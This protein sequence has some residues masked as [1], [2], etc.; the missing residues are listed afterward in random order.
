M[1]HFDEEISGSDFSDDDDAGE[2]PCDFVKFAQEQLGLNVD[3]TELEIDCP[4]DPILSGVL[5]IMRPWE[6]HHVCV[7]FSYVVWGSLQSHVANPLEATP[8]F[9]YAI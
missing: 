6:Y 3:L 5:F 2:K 9:E 7:L 8:S 1:Q 4:G